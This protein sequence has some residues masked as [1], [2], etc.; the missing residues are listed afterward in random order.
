MAELQI[1]EMIARHIQAGQPV[2]ID[3]QHVIFPG[4]VFSVG[5]ATNGTVAIEVALESELLAA[6]KPGVKVEGTI[7]FGR[8]DNILYLGRPVRCQ[9]DST[10]S[11][12]KLD[13]DGKT[14]VRTQVK[15][16]KSSV[17]TIEILDG[18]KVGDKVILSDVSAYDGVD[19][20]RLP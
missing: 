8:L 4:T 20:I 1:A 7:Q 15:F 3:I 6:V 11:L 2:S 18:L 10:G 9:P 14:L 17:N 16:G 5:S 12:F 13:A 19:R